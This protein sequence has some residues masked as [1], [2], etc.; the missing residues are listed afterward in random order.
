MIFSVMAH[1]TK[2]ANG[3]I[4]KSRTCSCELQSSPLNTADLGTGEKAAVFGGMGGGGGGRAKI[5]I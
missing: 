4:L 5:T 1:D 2:M 3:N